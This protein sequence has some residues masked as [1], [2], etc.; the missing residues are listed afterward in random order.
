MCPFYVK[1]TT[2]GA[3]SLP[4]QC[5]ERW[6]PTHTSLT[7]SAFQMSQPSIRQD[8]CI[9]TMSEYGK[10]EYHQTSGKDFPES[11]VRCGLLIDTVIVIVHIFS[12]KTLSAK[13]IFSDCFKTKVT[14]EHQVRHP[15]VICQLDGAPAHC[16][17]RVRDTLNA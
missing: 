10:I 6:K 8:L 3:K 17:L 2:N 1:E 16:G 14:P 11:N 13:P 15:Y 4:G 12:K 5:S 9:G 7:P